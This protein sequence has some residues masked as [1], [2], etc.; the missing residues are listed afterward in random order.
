MRKFITKLF[1]LACIPVLLMAVPSYL[2][3]KRDVYQDFGRHKN[4]SWT[5]SF[6]QLGDIGTKKL[7]GNAAYKYNS[8][9]FG[10]S[11]TTGIYACYLQQKIPNARFF[12]YAN[13]NESIGG[14]YEKLKLLDSLHYEINNV[15]IYVD[16]DFTFD[17]DGKCHSSDHYLLTGNSEKEYMLSHYRSFFT[18][19]NM[20]KLRILCGRHV[21]GGMFPNWQ[22]DVITNDCNHNCADTTVLADYGHVQHDEQL[23]HKIDSLK[24]AG[25]LYA[26]S[27][28]LTFKE[29][30]ISA[31]EEQM[32]LG[33]KRIFDKHATN[34]YVIITPLYDQKKFNP[35]DQQL[36]TRCFGPHLYDF[37]GINRFTAD[38]DNYPDGKHFQPYISKLIMDSVIS[39]KNNN[40]QMQMTRL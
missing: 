11:R 2:Y 29:K 23:R 33:I 16:T 7:L 13:W 36:L 8:F 38:P 39:G 37:S 17:G 24:K 15:V 32:L 1:F 21:S 27:A 22:S 35:A 14:I 18:S 30:Q 40:L 9:I 34:Y 31:G 25:I 20:D 4:Y 6:Q 26:R 12:H 19:F 5:Y 28:A 10:S 3:L